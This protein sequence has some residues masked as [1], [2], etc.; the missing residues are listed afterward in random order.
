MG[1]QS[2]KQTTCH[3]AGSHPRLKSNFCCWMIL[4]PFSE[5]TECVLRRCSSARG[6]AASVGV[7]NCLR[8][9]FSTVERVSLKYT[10]HSNIMQCFFHCGHHSEQITWV[11]SHFGRPSPCFL[12]WIQNSMREVD[13][14]ITVYQ[15]NNIYTGILKLT[16]LHFIKVKQQFTN[17]AVKCL[18]FKIII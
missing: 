7:S 4:Q 14:R 17:V 10:L 2:L 9:C 13:W 12:T 3:P 18:S 16:K 6:C 11:L 8:W 5:A 1:S 15:Q